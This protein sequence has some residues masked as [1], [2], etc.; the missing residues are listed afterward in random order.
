MEPLT[1]TVFAILTHNT[2]HNQFCL[3]IRPKEPKET[4]NQIMMIIHNDPI[5]FSW[6]YEL[7]NT[8]CLTKYEDEWR[9]VADVLELEHATTAFSEA[10]AWHLRRFFS[11]RKRHLF[12]TKFDVCKDIFEQLRNHTLECCGDIK[13]VTQ[14]E[15]LPAETILWIGESVNSITIT[16]S[17]E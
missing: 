6:K 4:D 17:K 16:D 10:D 3:R 11:L 5:W 1:V 2:K 9:L 14:K 8:P 12:S 13:T 7:I 15:S